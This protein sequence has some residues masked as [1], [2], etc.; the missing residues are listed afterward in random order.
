MQM[1]AERTWCFDLLFAERTDE[2]LAPHLRLSI[3]LFTRYGT[4][5]G[6]TA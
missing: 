4:S 1:A 6:A 2:T 3:A 5:S